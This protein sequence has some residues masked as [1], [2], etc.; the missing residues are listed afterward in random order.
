MTKREIGFLLI[1]LGIGL[2][3]SIAVT[4]DILATLHR[5][6]DIVAYSW[7]RGILAVPIL[8]VLVG[9]VLIVYRR[10]TIA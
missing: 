6:G 8:L 5:V 3:L 7:E 10:R 9:F 1:G 2:L 4:V